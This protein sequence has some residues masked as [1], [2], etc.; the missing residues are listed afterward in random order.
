MASDCQWVSVGSARQRALALCTWRPLM[1]ALAGPPLKES[2]FID[3]AQ[4]SSLSF[5][6]ADSK[7]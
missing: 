7:S 3:Q 2:I 6:A 4:S 1:L 5:F